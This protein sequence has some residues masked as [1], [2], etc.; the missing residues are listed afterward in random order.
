MLKTF[1]A[2][3]FIRYVEFYL[4]PCLF[5][6]HSFIRFYLFLFIYMLTTDVYFFVDLSRVK[7][8]FRH[9]FLCVYEFAPFFSLQTGPNYSFL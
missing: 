3:I 5:T 1:L 2:H 7:E 6:Y 8:L 9:T 4:C